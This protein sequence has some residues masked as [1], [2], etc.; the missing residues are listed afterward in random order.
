MAG[1]FKQK[2][3]KSENGTEYVFQHP[4]VRMISKINDQ[5]K[6]KFGVVSEERLAELMLK[7][8]VVTPKVTIDD[9]TDYEEY[10]AVI[11]NAYAF[12]TGKGDENDNEKGSEREGD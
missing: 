12:I 4:G 8:V 6:N 5:S 1:I 7:H 10:S 11:N 9:F 2:D 3:F